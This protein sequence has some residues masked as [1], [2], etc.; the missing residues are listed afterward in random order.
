MIKLLFS[1]GTLL[2]SSFSFAQS[3]IGS[4]G[5]TGGGLI[6]MQQIRSAAL[7][8]HCV[9]GKRV[10]I[11][12]ARGSLRYME[13]RT[14]TNGTYMTPEEQEAYIRVPRRPAKCKEGARFTETYHN[15]PSDRTVYIHKICV[16]GKWQTWGRE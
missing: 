6:T 15:D 11:E 1:L 5:S 4:G 13:Y 3:G 16:N 2:I 14:C 7:Q 12:V 9:E 8:S 10:G